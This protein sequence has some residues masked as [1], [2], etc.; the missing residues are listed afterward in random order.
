[1][2]IN[3][4]LGGMAASFL[5]QTPSEWIAVK[6]AINTPFSLARLS[7]KSESNYCLDNNAL[8]ICQTVVI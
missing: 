6:I 3:S 5:A 7:K 4:Q 1:M 8:C 2:L